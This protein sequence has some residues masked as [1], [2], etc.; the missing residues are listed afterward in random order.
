MGGWGISKFAIDQEHFPLAGPSSRQWEV[1]FNDLSLKLSNT[2]ILDG[3]EQV[4][5]H[6]PIANDDTQIVL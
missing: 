2:Q 5:M 1:F 6:Q 3:F 4:I